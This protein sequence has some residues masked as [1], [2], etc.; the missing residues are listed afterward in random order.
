MNDMIRHRL[1]LT[2]LLLIGCAGSLARSLTA[3]DYR[4][5]PLSEAPPEALSAD[6]VKLLSVEGVRVIRGEKS[7]FCDIWLRKELNPKADFQAT[8]EIVYPFVPGQLVGAIRYGRR[9]ADYRDQR[10]DRGVY[11]L[12]YAHQPVDGAHVGTSLTRDFLVLINAKHD[13]SGEELEYDSLTEHSAEAVGTSHP[14]ML[15]LQRIATDG[16]RKKMRHDGRHDWW[17]VPLSGCSGEQKAV[18]LDVVVVGFGEE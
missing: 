13:Q 18:H 17:I 9:G 10:I 1:L 11:T 14:G 5:E 16:D 12:R 3:Q 8:A 15:S 2:L 6:I 7:K 4:M